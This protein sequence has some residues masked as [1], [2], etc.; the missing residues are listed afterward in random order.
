MDGSDLIGLHD[1]Y[2]TRPG[3]RKQMQNEICYSFARD[4]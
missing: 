3:K 4:E 2:A 1:L